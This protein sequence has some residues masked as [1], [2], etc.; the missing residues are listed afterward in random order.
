[1]IGPCMPYI[2][3]QAKL[4][5]RVQ[6][7]M[8]EIYLLSDRRVYVFK[9]DANSDSCDRILDDVFGD[10]RSH[11]ASLFRSVEGIA[12]LDMLVSFTK[13]ASMQ[14]YIRPEYQN[15]LAIAAGRHPIHERFNYI[16]QG[17]FVPK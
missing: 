16:Q 9:C 14:N 2:E 7:S 4:N 3:V 1:M 5:G 10:I 17:A 15:A 13:A 11:I 6:N 12:L 8:D